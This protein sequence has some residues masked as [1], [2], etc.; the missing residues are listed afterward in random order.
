MKDE[1]IVEE[2]DAGKIDLVPPGTAFVRSGS[3][4]PFRE[5]MRAGN[6]PWEVTR[7]GKK[8][9]ITGRSRNL[10]DWSLRGIPLRIFW[11]QYHEI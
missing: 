2:V 6:D 10:S 3:Q 7:S 4:V 9:A 1:G 8:E 5:Y 11:I